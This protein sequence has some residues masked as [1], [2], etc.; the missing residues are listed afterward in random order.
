[1]TI[2]RFKKTQYIDIKLA[3]AIL[4]LPSTVS[5]SSVPHWESTAGR[6]ELLYHVTQFLSQVSKYNYWFA[7]I[8]QPKNTKTHQ[9]TRF[10]H[11]TRKDLLRVRIS[12]VELEISHERGVRGGV[13][14]VN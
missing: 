13:T 6:K 4:A 5:F 9:K 14:Q 8:L 3:E 1:M 10:S 7:C 12:E 2:E 11:L